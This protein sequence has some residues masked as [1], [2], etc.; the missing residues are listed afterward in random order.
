MANKAFNTINDLSIIKKSKFKKDTRYY[1]GDNIKDA[2]NIHS[3]F[4]QEN[5][6]E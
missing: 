1:I 4:L 2:K 6:I 3:L 5:Q